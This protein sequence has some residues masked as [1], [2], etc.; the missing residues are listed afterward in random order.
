MKHVKSPKKGEFTSSL[1]LAHGKTSCRREVGRKGVPTVYVPW[2][3]T[4]DNIDLFSE[5][6]L[7]ERGCT[8][9]RGNEHSIRTPKDRV[10]KISTW[11][12]LPYI[13]KDELQRVIDD[14]PE[15]ES[16]G[17][18][19]F[20]AATVASARVSRNMQT[21]AQV[22]DQLKHL[23]EDMSS[24]KLSNV[25]SKYRQLPES[26]YGGDSSKLSAW[27]TQYGDHPSEVWEWYSGSSTLSSTSKRNKLF[28]CLLSTIDTDGI[29][30]NVYI[31][32][33]LSMFF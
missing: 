8:I 1:T 27:R 23:R 28:T 26:Y 20:Q 9:I 18:S 13:T 19:G 21:S 25:C 31:K 17:R 30:P 32:Q 22:R 12:G 11:G 15:A 4:L 24:K 3:D 5:G 6:F 33:K 29:C 7:W 10:I 16:E 14:L 2:D